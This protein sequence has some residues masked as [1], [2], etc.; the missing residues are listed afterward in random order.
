LTR[1]VGILS[2]IHS[3]NEIHK[4]IIAKLA[5]AP[6]DEEPSQSMEGAPN[7]VSPSLNGAA[8]K[9]PPGGVSLLDNDA[10]TSQCDDTTEPSQQASCDSSIESRETVMGGVGHEEDG[11]RATKRFKT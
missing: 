11:G 1:V 3:E 4:V 6:H 7:V 8:S 9:R 2:R 5:R 10:G